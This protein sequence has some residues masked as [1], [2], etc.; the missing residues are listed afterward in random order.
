M[1]G[2]LDTTFF[3]TPHAYLMLQPQHDTNNGRWSTSTTVSF[4]TTDRPQLIGRIFDSAEIFS[5]MAIVEPH[6]MPTPSTSLVY[7]AL[8]P[9]S[10]Y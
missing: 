5:D 6:L 10:A 1:F 2:E 4:S 8:I 7:I 9:V 3:E